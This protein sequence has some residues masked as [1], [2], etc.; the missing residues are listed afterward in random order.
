[1]PSAFLAKISFLVI[2]ASLPSVQLERFIRPPFLKQMLRQLDDKATG[3]WRFLYESNKKQIQEIEK[4][5]EV[6]KRAHAQ[7]QK[8]Q[9][10]IDRYQKLHDDLRKM[11]KEIE[12]RLKLKKP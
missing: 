12:S 2:S 8:M 4:K 3:H 11:Q 5:I 10:Y 9:H 7:G 1:M 6:L